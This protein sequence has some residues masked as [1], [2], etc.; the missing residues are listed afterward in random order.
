MNRERFYDRLF[1]VKDEGRLSYLE[2]CLGL[3][4]FLGVIVFRF[5]YLSFVV[6]VFGVLLILLK[7]LSLF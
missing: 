2:Y 7:L 6:F 3:F 4:I 1:F 5:C